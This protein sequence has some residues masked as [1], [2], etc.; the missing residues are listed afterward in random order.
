MEEHAPKW[1]VWMRHPE[2]GILGALGAVGMKVVAMRRPW[3]IKKIT[4]S[5]KA[6]VKALAEEM[7]WRGLG[8][9]MC[10]REVYLWFQRETEA[11]ATVVEEKKT[12][13]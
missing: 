2:V 5:D 6:Q 9:G 4:W 10:G 1:D 7:E 11:P 12:V 13:V 3:V 8:G